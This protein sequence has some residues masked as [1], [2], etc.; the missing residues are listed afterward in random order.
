MD[1]W[2]Y[3]RW[4]ARN[5]SLQLDSGLM[6]DLAV[7]EKRTVLQMRIGGLILLR[8][9]IMMLLRDTSIVSEVP[10]P[11]SRIHLKDGT[12]SKGIQRHASC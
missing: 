10:K 7:D 4:S 12:K 9:N 2:K 1:W 5:V 8:R 11:F 3:W 6:D